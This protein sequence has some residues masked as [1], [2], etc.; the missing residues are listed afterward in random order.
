MNK[1]NMPKK[2]IN[3]YTFYKIVS[4]YD[5]IELCYVGS[6]ADFNKRR[7][8]HKN[9]YKNENSKSY[10]NK[11]YKT[12]RENGGF[13]NFKFIVLGTRE[14]LTKREA[15]QIEETYRNEI[16]AEL[17]SRRCYETEE[18]R[19][20]QIKKW[21]EENKEKVLEYHKNWCEDNKEYQQKYRE[22][23]KEKFKELQKKWREDNKEKLNEKNKKYREFN[24]DKI[25][26]KMNEKVKC[27]C[28]CLIRKYDLLKHKKTKK[29]LKN[30]NCL[31]ANNNN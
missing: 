8:E 18:E 2:I 5:D 14:Q 6:T 4:I 26:E 7:S 12:I 24:R 3:D 21:R 19:K 27:D 20:K 11:L 28:G 31:T 10:N 23:N 15:E 30:M 22:D 13:N 17:N 16:K 9:T 1:N 25:K 29:H